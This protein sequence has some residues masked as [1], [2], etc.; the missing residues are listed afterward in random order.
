MESARADDAR[1]RSIFW[2]D[3]RRSGLPRNLHVELYPS[4]NVPL[5]IH[6]D[7]CDTSLPAFSNPDRIVKNNWPLRIRE[8]P[9]GHRS[10]EARDRAGIVFRM[11]S[12]ANGYRPIPRSSGLDAA[13]GISREDRLYERLPRA[14]GIRGAQQ[15]RS[16]ARSSSLARTRSHQ[17]VAREGRQLIRAQR[18]G[19]TFMTGASA[20]EH[21]RWI[22]L[23]ARACMRA[24]ATLS[25]RS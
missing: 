19:D 14:S 15:V 4:A 23:V 21:R 22:S 9:S 20:R 12:I 18:A 1:R 25:P 2:L 11:R 16:H 10:S 6:S 8:S 17:Q 7:R 13:P 5:A 3:D 24:C